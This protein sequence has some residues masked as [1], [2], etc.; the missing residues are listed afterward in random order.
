MVVEYYKGDDTYVIFGEEDAYGAVSSPAPVVANFI[1]RVTSGA[2]N[3]SNNLIMSQGVGEGRNVTQTVYGAFS[4]SGTVSWEVND[5]TFIQYVIG[6]KQ[7]AG[8][9]GDPFELKELDSFGY[10]DGTDIPTITLE[11]GNKGTT[12]SQVKQIDGCIIDSVTL[13]AV[14]E[15]LLTATCSW[16]GRNV[17]RSTSLET[18]TAPTERVFVFQQGALELGTSS[19]AEESIEVSSFV[20]TVAQNTI[21][22]TA[23]GSRFNIFPT[24]GNR[25]YTF[26]I[27]LRKKLDT[28]TAST[29]DSTEFLGFFLD[30]AKTDNTPA[31]GGNPS[32]LFLNLDFTEGAASGDR[33]VEIELQ[34]VFLDS[35][36][37]T[38]TLGNFVELSVTGHA[39]SGLADGADKL[40]LRWYS[41]A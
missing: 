9:I 35:W 14:K 40:P 11:I 26:V 37:D 34:D 8:T 5:F 32:G 30:A 15:Q 1:G 23:L 28:T 3:M 13:S 18:Y 38:Y 12:T 31:T 20:L 29:V 22:D 10:V 4:V 17:T 27:T 7:G 24:P 33:V 25:R 36:G 39:H 19:G 41:I 16:I 6:N 2:T 21:T